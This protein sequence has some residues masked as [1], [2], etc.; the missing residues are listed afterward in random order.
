MNECT[1]SMTSDENL[2]T[3]QIPEAALR[4][5]TTDR[6]RATSRISL[7]IHCTI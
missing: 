1:A 3:L 2:L 5:R 7:T 6:G 4:A